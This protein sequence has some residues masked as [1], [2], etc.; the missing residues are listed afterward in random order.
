[1]GFLPA[2]PVRLKSTF[3]LHDGG[4]LLRETLILANACQEC[5]LRRG[6]ASCYSPFP[7]RVKGYGRVSPRSFPQ[8]WKKLW[9][10]TGA[11]VGIGP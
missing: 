11:K 4:R 9:K 2:P 8:L 7:A 6:I 10:S 1:M 3:A 5:Q